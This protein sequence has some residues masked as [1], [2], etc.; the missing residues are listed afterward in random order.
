MPDFDHVVV[1]A[2]MTGHAAAQ[3][4]RAEDGTAS[5]ALIGDEPV[6]PY[7]RPPLSKGLWGGQGEGSIWLPEVAGA[8]VLAG[9]RVASIES[10]AAPRPPGGR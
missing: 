6:G 8:K 10:Q 5:I 9:K 2:G 7:V 4:I 1:G 3:G